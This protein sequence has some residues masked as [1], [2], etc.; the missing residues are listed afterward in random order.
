MLIQEFGDARIY[1][2]NSRKLTVNS[3]AFFFFS[4]FF[5]LIMKFMSYMAF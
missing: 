4:K 5:L 2:G 3:F 1:L